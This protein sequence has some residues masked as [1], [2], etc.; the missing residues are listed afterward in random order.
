MGKRYE[1]Q[2]AV[3]IC[4]WLLQTQ[5]RA[6]TVRYIYS[7]NLVPT[8]RLWKSIYSFAWWHSFIGLVIVG[9]RAVLGQ[10]TIWSKKTTKTPPPRTINH[11]IQ[12]LWADSTWKGKHFVAKKPFDTNL[13]DEYILRDCGFTYLLQECASPQWCKL[14]YLVPRDE[15]IWR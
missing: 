5:L 10:L 8:Y 14:I 15:K 2:K 12:I 9:Q 3:A 1:N 11:F 13:L 7:A 4:K 6:D